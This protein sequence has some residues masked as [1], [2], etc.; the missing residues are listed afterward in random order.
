MGTCGQHLLAAGQPQRV[1]E[2]RAAERLAL[3]ARLHRRVV[4]VDDV[5]GAQQHVALRRRG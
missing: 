3:D 4:V 2:L 1:E 5:V